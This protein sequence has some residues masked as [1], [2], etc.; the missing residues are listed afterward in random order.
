MDAHLLKVK[1]ESEGIPCYLFD[2]HLSEI[3][4]THN[5]STGGVRLKIDETHAEHAL[6]VYQAY[7]LQTKGQSSVKACPK[8]HNTQIKV[9]QNKKSKLQ[10]FLAAIMVLFALFPIKS[11]PVLLQCEDCGEVF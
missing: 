9:L 5:F 11:K 7:E 8:C 10:L 2:E 6:E 3:Y 4:P 1:L